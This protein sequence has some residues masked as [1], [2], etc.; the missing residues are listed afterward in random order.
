MPRGSSP[1]FMPTVYLT[2]PEKVKGNVLVFTHEGSPSVFG[3]RLACS[4]LFAGFFLVGKDLGVYLSGV[5][6]CSLDN[7]GRA[8]SRRKSHAAVGF[9]RQCRRLRSDHGRGCCGWDG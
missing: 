1:A 6:G 3:M 8:R 5:C 2:Y 4:G 7:W 9:S